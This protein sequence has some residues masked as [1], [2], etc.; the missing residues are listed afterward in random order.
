MIDVYL[1]SH[2]FTVTR[3]L[4]TVLA[5]HLANSSWHKFAISAAAALA[6]P[7]PQCHERSPPQP[8]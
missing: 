1:I 3:S 8:V 7:T 4:L 2:A 6:A 5:S